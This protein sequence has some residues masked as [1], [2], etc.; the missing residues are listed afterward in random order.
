MLKSF[1]GQY[2]LP[3]AAHN[4][5]WERKGRCSTYSTSDSGMRARHR[6]FHGCSA[7]EQL[8][9]VH[10]MELNNTW[11]KPLQ[12]V[13]LRENIDTSKYLS[14]YVSHI[15]IGCPIDDTARIAMFSS[16]KNTREL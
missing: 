16:L 15:A 6:M 5:S 14:V 9:A 8:A 13:L 1:T 2:V 4:V 3:T 12:L 11:T 7:C 10:M